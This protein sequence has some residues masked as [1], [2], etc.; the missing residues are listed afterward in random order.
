MH[1]QMATLS[2]LMHRMFGGVRLCLFQGVYEIA[3]MQ[4]CMSNFST[5][6]TTGP[7]SSHRPTTGVQLC[8]G[9]GFFAYVNSSLSHTVFH[10]LHSL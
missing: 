8:Y 9:F 5:F 6:K 10:T 2:R 1:H 4:R 7:S 3:V